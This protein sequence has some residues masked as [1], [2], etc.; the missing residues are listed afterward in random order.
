MA[1]YTNSQRSPEQVRRGRRMA[2]LLFFVGFGPII[3]A[4]AMYYTGWFNPEGFANKGEL[5]HP[6][7]SVAALNLRDSEGE[8]VEDRFGPDIEDPEWVMLVTSPGLCAEECQQMLYLARQVNIALG[9]NANRVN[10]AAYLESIPS[11]L[12]EE[13][14]EEYPSMAL[15][16]TEKTAGSAWPDAVAPDSKPRIL[17][18]D[19]FGNIMMRY[20][21]EHTGKELIKDLKHL[22]KLSQIG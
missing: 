11:D 5:I 20:N 4:T 12:D 19:P 3:L 10:R 13:M 16:T 8:P 2:V 15:L 18:V 9:K 6:P 21:S 7:V 14:R 17:L 22:L 1:E